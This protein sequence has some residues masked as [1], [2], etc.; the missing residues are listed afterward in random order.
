MQMNSLPLGGIRRH[1]NLDEIE[2]TLNI[3]ETRPILECVI[4]F[5]DLV[6]S[7]LDLHVHL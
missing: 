3:W 6:F 1:Y 2:M 7:C 4:V 5:S